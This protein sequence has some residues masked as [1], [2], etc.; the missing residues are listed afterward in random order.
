MNKAIS[1]FSGLVTLAALALLA[2]CAQFGQTMFLRGRD[3]DIKQAT[4]AIAAAARD[5]GRRAK[6]FSS[7]GAAYSEKARYCRAFKL[8]PSHEY[9][10]L[11]DLAMQDHNQAVSLNPHD[12]EVYFNRGQAYYDRAGLEI[13]ESKAA[14]SWFD[15]A[16]SDFEKAAAN[17]PTKYLAFDRLGLAYEA[18]GKPDQALAAYTK[19]MALNS[20]GKSRLADAYCNIGFRYQKQKD[21]AAALAAYQRSTQ[22]GPADVKSCPNEPFAALLAIYTTETHQYDKA[23]ETLHQ[24]NKAGQRIAPELIDHLKQASGRAN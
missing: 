15:A 2:G 11:F 7:R 5:N 13:L 6:A 23:W 9:L 12:A 17:D 4:E 19:E 8:I 1:S 10:R 21:H 14:S 16:A 20:L 22:F 24:A 3:N 18:N